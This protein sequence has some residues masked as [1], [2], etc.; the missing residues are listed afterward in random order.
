MYRL[1]PT[2]TAELLTPPESGMGYQLVEARLSNQKVERAIAYN[3]ELVVLDSEPR[4]DLTDAVRRYALPN[5]AP[6]SHVFTGSPEPGT[7]I[8]RGVAMPLFGQPGGGVEVIFP[9]G[10]Q[11]FTVTGPVKIPDV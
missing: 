5:P 2:L 7:D 8:Q 4:A 1:S 3:A 6:A 10:T 9:A 11:P